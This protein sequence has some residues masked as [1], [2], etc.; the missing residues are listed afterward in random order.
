[1]NLHGSPCPQRIPL[2]HFCLE[3]NILDARE[4]DP[5]HMVIAL[6]RLAIDFLVCACM[7][8]LCCK[9][10]FMWNNF[11]PACTKFANFRNFSQH[12]FQKEASPTSYAVEGNAKILGPKCTWY[13]HF[14]L[15]FSLAWSSSDWVWK[16]SFKLWRLIYQTL[17]MRGYLYFT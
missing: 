5:T 8:D 15:T 2:T 12:D 10:I 1:M 13:N 9:A 17:G 14:S 7:W 16:Y 3:S 4:R 11:S 6:R